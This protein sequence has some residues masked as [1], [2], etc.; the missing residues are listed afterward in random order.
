[1]RCDR[2]NEPERILNFAVAVTPKLVA[3]RK[4]YRATSRKSLRPGRIRIRKI[5]GQAKWPLAG[6]NRFRPK[7]RE[8]IVQHHCGV[9]NADARVHKTTIR[10]R[11]AC[12]FNGIESLLQK[13]DVLGGPVH[14]KVSSERMKTCGKIAG[15]F[16]HGVIVSNSGAAR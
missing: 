15:R 10:R 4:H 5:E 7:L 13:F 14:R 1:M 9:P 11:R 16:W 6:T 8:N 12:E 3:H 2:P